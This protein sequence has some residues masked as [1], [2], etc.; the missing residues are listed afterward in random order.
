LI[1]EFNHQDYIISFFRVYEKDKLLVVC[2]F[3][4]D[5]L[6]KEIKLADKME[7]IKIFDSNIGLVESKDRFETTKKGDSYSL[8]VEVD[9]FSI[10]IFERV[11]N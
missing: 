11:L 8:L 7:F 4:Q 1:E 3:S 5:R 2:N 6:K 9:S 10:L